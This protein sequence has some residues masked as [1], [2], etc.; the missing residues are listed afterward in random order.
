MSAHGRDGKPYRDW[1]DGEAPNPASPKVGPAYALQ[2]QVLV[3]SNDLVSLEAVIGDRIAALEANAN[4]R[5]AFLESMAT[6]R[7]S[8]SVP[9]GEI[10]AIPKARQMGNNRVMI[11]AAEA[12]KRGEDMTCFV[13][14]FCGAVQPARPSAGTKEIQARQTRKEANAL[15]MKCRRLAPRWQSDWSAEL[16]DGAADMIEELLG[17]LEA[18]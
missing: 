13:E 7:I 18:K 15:A 2:D 3:L 5:L 16:L 12:F 9:D 4:R 14:R 1:A 6:I 8:D 17:Q 10:R 11:E